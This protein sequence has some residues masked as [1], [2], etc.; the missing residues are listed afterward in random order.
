MI[1]KKH[2]V[3]LTAVLVLTVIL[4]TSFLPASAS[5]LT[6]SINAPSIGYPFSENM[7][8]YTSSGKI[9]AYSD[10]ALTN[11]IGRA[12]E[13]DTMTIIATGF[14]N[15]V[16]YAQCLC[17]WDGWSSPRSIFVRLQDLGVDPAYAMDI[18]NG[19]IP[20]AKRA[21][22]RITTYKHCN[23]TKA[24]YIEKGDL[25]FVVGAAVSLKKCVIYPISRQTVNGRSCEWKMAWI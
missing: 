22:Q 14:T 9:N 16:P 13:T 10:A 5:A 19:V 18:R 8:C 11:Y 3:R 2:F 24:G 1:T 20:V 15:G 23:G 17:P 21:T 12:Y 4:A 6:L 7:V 25:Y